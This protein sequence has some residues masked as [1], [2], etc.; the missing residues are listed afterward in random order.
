[1]RRKSALEYRCIYVI[2]QHGIQLTIRPSLGIYHRYRVL[3]LNFAAAPVPVRKAR[4]AVPI[5]G[6]AGISLANSN[7]AMRNLA[8]F[9]LIGVVIQQHILLIQKTHG[10]GLT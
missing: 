7:W 2:L 3:G 9:L 10:G 5:A 1:M 6:L 8:S 4:F